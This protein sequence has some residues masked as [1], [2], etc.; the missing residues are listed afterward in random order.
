[1]QITF[2]TRL[3]F[4]MLLLLIIGGVEVCPG[5][6]LSPNLT[7]GM[8]NTR[9]VINKAPLLH[10]LITDNDLSIL[11]E[12]WA[13]GDDPQVIKNGP[14][15]PGYRICIYAGIIHIKI[16]VVASLLFTGTQSIFNLES[17]K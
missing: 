11:T 6:S 3:N 10:S 8:L 2:R 15:P 13:K 1:M 14:T 5:P 7:F 16:G 17:I 4:S 12:T 9:S